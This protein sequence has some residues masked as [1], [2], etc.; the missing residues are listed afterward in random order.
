[1]AH[2]QGRIAWGY[3]FASRRCRRACRKKGQ[4]ASQPRLALRIS[5]G[6][7]GAHYKRATHSGHFVGKALTLTLFGTV[8]HVS[9]CPHV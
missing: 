4:P 5:S 3:S 2:A 7:S 9:E 8:W 1:M 6:R